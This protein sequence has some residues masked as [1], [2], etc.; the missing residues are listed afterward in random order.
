MASALVAK[1][2]SCLTLYDPMD[3]SLPA[4][5]V[6][7]IPRQEYWS[8]LPFPSP[9]DL[10]YPGIESASPASAGR[11]FTAQLALGRELLTIS[12]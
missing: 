8:E 11:F 4:S 6:H 9:G 1:C 10:L 7:G 5:P 2:K 12:F 3:W